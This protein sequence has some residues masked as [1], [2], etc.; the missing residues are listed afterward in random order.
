MFCV[1]NVRNGIS[2]LNDKVPDWAS[3]IN[4]D[5]LDMDSFTDCILGQL[6]SHFNDGFRALGLNDNTSRSHGF[7]LPY[8]ET[9][10]SYGEMKELCFELRHTW[11]SLIREQST[12]EEGTMNPVS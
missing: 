1:S 4:L 2:L 10:G 7:L 12:N 9:W 3:R 8:T 6:F 5:K 11:I